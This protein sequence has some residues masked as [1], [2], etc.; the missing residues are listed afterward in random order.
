MKFRQN[1]FEEKV[2]YYDVRY[3]NSLILFR[4]SKKGLSLEGI[5]YCTNLQ[6]R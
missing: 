6:E 3:V 2:K 5:Y 4:K 1:W